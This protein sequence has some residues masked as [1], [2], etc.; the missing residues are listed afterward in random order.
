MVGHYA[1][2]Y[3]ISWRKS[4]WDKPAFGQV[5]KCILDVG[6]ANKNDLLIIPANAFPDVDIIIDNRI[7]NSDI[8]NSS[9]V[10]SITV[11]ISLI[12]RGGLMSPFPTSI[13]II[14]NFISRMIFFMMCT[15]FSVILFL[16]ACCCA[17]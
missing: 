10:K 9:C 5:L 11:H 16:F 4:L 14:C 8:V 1:A 12:A 17:V 2:T 15:D 13:V 7:Y 3:W 6:E